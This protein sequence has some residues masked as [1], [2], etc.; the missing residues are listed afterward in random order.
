MI[1]RRLT[2]AFR[3]QDW[4]TVAVETLIVVFGV[5]IGLQVNNW[6]TE[7]GERQLEAKYRLLLV[8]DLRAIDATL[9]EQLEHEV[10]VTIAAGVAFQEIS[11]A[12][13]S[14]DPM[15]IGQSLMQVWGRRTLTL[16]SPTFSELKGAGRLTVI[17]DTGLRRD[18][19]GYFEQ[20]NRIELVFE[21]NNDF[22]V[23]P[24]TAFLRDSGIGFV[25]IPEHLCDMD[26][27]SVQCFLS[28]DLLAIAQGQKTHSA[29]SILNAPSDDP[30]WTTLR[31]HLAYRASAASSNVRRAED[32]RIQTREIIAMLEAAP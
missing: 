22:I 7:R 27:P 24:F 13:T 10:G 9:A 18:L 25:P 6:N 11:D 15:S 1:L 17:K 19:I 2:T 12:G 26:A 8:S 14:S 4:F 32:A 31:A 5:Y 28:N 30:I 20:L 3:K 23:E 16:E 21:K 29:D